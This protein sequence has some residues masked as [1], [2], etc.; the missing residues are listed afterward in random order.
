METITRPVVGD[1]EYL[2]TLTR[3]VITDPDKWTQHEYGTSDGAQCASGA[4]YT[5]A[6]KITQARYSETYNLL[7]EIMGGRIIDFNDT[8]THAEVL[9]AFDAAIAE[10]K[11]LGV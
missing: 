8:H 3:A 9:A 6:A 7:R 10:A 1:V 5:T 11:R 2:L 4:L